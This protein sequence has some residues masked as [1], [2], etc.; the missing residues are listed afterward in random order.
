MFTVT[1]TRD[2]GGHVVLDEERFGGQFNL[3]KEFDDRLAKASKED[4]RKFSELIAA[5]LM[6]AASAARRTS[7]MRRAA[8]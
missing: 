5:A 3:G 7:V 6:T 8:F 4:R 2:G 1:L